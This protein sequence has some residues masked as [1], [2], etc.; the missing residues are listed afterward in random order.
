MER[1]VKKKII[2]YCDLEKIGKDIF[3]Y[4]VESGEFSERQCRVMVDAIT[5]AI[6]S[7]GDCA[8][9]MTKPNWMIRKRKTLW[10]KG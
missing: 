7:T 1:V 2:H 3:K 4:L 10:N 9:V 6:V 8:D 5:R